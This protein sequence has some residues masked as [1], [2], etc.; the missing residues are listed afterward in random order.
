MEASWLFEGAHDRWI[1][2]YTPKILYSRHLGKDVQYSA[3]RVVT[4]SGEMMYV[5]N[6]STVR[7]STGTAL[8]ALW[9]ATAPQ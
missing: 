2:N 6:V 3:Y 7:R 9:H 8:P 1:K 4:F 5:R